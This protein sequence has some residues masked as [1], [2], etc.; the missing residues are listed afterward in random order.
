LPCGWPV[1]DSYAPTDTG[2]WWTLAA[3]KARICALIV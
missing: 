1:V 2:L 3:Q